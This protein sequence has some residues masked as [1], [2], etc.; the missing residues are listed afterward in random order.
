MKLGLGQ[1]SR[2]RFRRANELSSGS[3]LKCESVSA[4]GDLPCK[5]QG[6]EGQ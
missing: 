2:Q 5:E 3:K 1:F 6:T 4:L